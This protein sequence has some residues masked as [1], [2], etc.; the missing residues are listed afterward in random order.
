MQWRLKRHLI[1]KGFVDEVLIEG[2]SKRSDKDFAG[3]NDQNAMAIF[4]VD[5]RYQAGD[6]VTVLIESCTSATLLGKIVD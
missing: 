5:E 2:F 6:Y 3:R 1:N 4:P